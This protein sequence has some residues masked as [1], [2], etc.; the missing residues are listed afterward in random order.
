MV[1]AKAFFDLQL[2]FAQRISELSGLPL[3]RVLLEY[4]NLYVRFGLG[5]DFRPGN[6]VWQAYLV[7]AFPFRR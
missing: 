6:P 4:T 5:R 1:Y 7:S 2:R 3:P